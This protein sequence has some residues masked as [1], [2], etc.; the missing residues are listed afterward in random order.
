MEEMTA[1]D[2]AGINADRA[3]TAAQVDHAP[4]RSIEAEPAR[5]VANLLN[6][7]HTTLYRA[8]VA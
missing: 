4:D 5:Y 1:T 7:G 6:V 2:K 8:L 3:N